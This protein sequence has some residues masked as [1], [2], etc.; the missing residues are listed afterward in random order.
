MIAG[1][2]IWRTAL[3]LWA[4]VV[5]LTCTFWIVCSN[6]KAANCSNVYKYS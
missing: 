6:S 4:S 2:I 5:S 1:T 3:Q